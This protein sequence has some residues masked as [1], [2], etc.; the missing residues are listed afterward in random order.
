MR[1]KP[2]RIKNDIKNIAKYGKLEGGGVSRLAFTSADFEAR[3]YFE[4]SLQCLGMEVMVDAIGN[5]RARREG[6]I[7]TAPVMIGSHLDSVPYGGC[8]DGVV[9]VV[10]ALEVVRVLDEL[11]IKTKRP[12]DIINIAAEESSRFGASTL[13]SKAMAGHL[14][15]EKMK[16]YKDKE[17]ISLYDA[18]QSCGLQPDALDSVK[19]KPGEIYA[20]IEM[21]IEQG[22]V[23]ESKGIPLGIVTSIAAP[24]RI[25]VFVK[26]RADHSGATPMNIR[27]DAL[28]AASEIILGVE[29]IAISGAGEHTVGTVGYANAKPGVLNVIPGLVELGIDIRD[30]EMESKD[31]AVGKVIALMDEISYKRQIEIKYEILADEVPVTLSDKIIS[32]IEKSIQDLGYQ[33]LLMPSGAGHDSMYMAEVTNTGMIFVPSREGISHNIKEYTPIEDIA[34]GVETMLETVLKLAN[35]K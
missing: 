29:R 24:T 11:G 20:F 35:E 13:G 21:H 10:A 7:D 19:I 12:I 8:Y 23:L 14:T 3:E 5:M 28:S 26:G 16:A 4:K 6:L 2:E 22:R 9:G 18:L 32:E 33:Y 30:I 31:M 25:K 17:G 34:M 1:I 15:V 27:S